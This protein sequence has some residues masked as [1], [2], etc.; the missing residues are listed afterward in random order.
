MKKPYN[1][2]NGNM[3]EVL[4]TLPENYFDSCITDPPYELNFMGK[5]WDNSG[6]AFQKETWEKVLRVLKPGAYLLAFGGTRTFHRIACAIE[7]AGFEIRDCI[8]WLYGSGFPKGLNI[9]KSTNN[10]KWKGW[11]TNLKPSYE[12][13]IVARKPCENSIT[14]NVMKY[15]TG[16]INID[17][18]RVGDELIKGGTMPD[19][20]YVGKEQVK[21][22]NGH[23]MSFGQV[24]NAPRIECEEHIGRFPAN[25]ILTDVNTEFSRYFYSAK[26]SNKDRDEGLDM[27]EAKQKPEYCLH[28]DN[29]KKR[30]EDITRK[31]IH[32]TVKPIELMQYLI[33]LITPTGGGN[34]GLFCW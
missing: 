5:G 17:G 28:Y 20:D 21:N 2:F 14:E 15:G 31:N 22:G 16:A 10:E 1:I 26:A 4:P 33:R 8:M 30:N 19:L 9:Y 11:G 7:D 24:N 29:G 3:L 23:K 6:V 12:P 18:C 32:P 13:I 25:T 34:I 27:F